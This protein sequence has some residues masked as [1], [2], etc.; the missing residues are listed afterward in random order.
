MPVECIT[1]GHVGI[2]EDHTRNH[3]FKIDRRC[4]I[5]CLDNGSAVGST[6]CVDKVESEARL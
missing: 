3:T 5:K 6:Y 4:R 1:V 2:V